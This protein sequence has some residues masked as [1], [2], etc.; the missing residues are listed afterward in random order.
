MPSKIFNASL[1]AKFLMIDRA[2]TE[3][4]QSSYAKIHCVKSVRIWVILVRMFPHLERMRRDTQDDETR[5]Y[6]GRTKQYLYEIYER[7]LE[8][9]RSFSLTCADFLKSKL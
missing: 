3:V 5:R 8:V 1:G 4:S 2:T 6:Q 7:N 9:F